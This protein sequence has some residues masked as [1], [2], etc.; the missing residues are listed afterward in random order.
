MAEALRRRTGV[1]ARTLVGVAGVVLEALPEGAL[2]WA[3]ERLLVVAD[4]HLEK[5]SSFARRGQLLPPYDTVETL[6]RLARLVGATDPAVVLC[7]G[8][9]FHDGDGPARLSPR[10]RATLAAL[11]QGRDWIWVAGNHDPSP[12]GLAGSHVETLAVGPLLFRH[13]PL[14]GPAIG[15]YLVTFLP[16]WTKGYN[17]QLSPVIFGAVLILL[18]MVAP[19][20]IMGL[21]RQVRAWAARQIGGRGD[22]SPPD[23]ATALVSEPGSGGTSPEG[24]VV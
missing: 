9:S 18:M 12:H 21:L 19:G 1:A 15:A 16:E 8:D 24:S 4:L 6:A 22:R 17:D 23:A 3:D 20:G 14:A 2:W 13:L 5:G 10:N 11:Q 7:L